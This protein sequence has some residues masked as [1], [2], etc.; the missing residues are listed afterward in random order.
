MQQASGAVRHD[1]SKQEVSDPRSDPQA[2]VG[3]VAAMTCI[4]A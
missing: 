4:S 2:T 3:K 1:L